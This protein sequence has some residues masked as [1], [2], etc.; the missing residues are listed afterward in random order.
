METKEELEQQ[1]R[2]SLQDMGRTIKGWLPPQFGFILL[3]PWMGEGGTMLYTA[4]VSR[5]DALQAMR[6]FI[7]VNMEERNWQREMPKL[8]SDEEF[9]AWWA[10]QLERVPNYSGNKMVRTMCRDAFLAGRSSA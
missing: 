6:E 4:S 7:A 1:I 8:E 10:K 9:E 3:V 5:P 2:S